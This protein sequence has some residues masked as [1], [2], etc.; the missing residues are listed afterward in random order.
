VGNPITDQAALRE[1]LSAVA[2]PSAD[3]YSTL[4]EYR[5]D[6]DKTTG[7]IAS[8]EKSAG[9]SMAADEQAVLLLEEQIAEAQAQSDQQVAL[10]QSQLE[11]LLGIETAIQT[12]A[13]AMAAFKNAKAG[14]FAGV[15]PVTGPTTAAFGSSTNLDQFADASN[16]R[17]IQKIYSDVL[18][19]GADQAGLQYYV[20]LARESMSIAAIS[21]LISG[22]NEAMTGAIPQFASGG[23]HSGGWRMVGERGPELEYTGPS[24]V[25]SNTASKAAL[26]NTAVVAE[27][28]SL[29]SEQTAI[30]SSVARNSARTA[31][32][33]DKWDNIGQPGVDP[34]SVGETT[35]VLGL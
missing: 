1:A 3:T 4:E 29:R 32:I 5:K 8:L 21:D 16:A 27:L 23:M 18:G 17:A 22:S 10:L 31:Q 15:A 7:V 35:T 19:R 13:E 6:F 2:S 33:L 24:K 14:G 30:G 26:D 28:R 34:D 11:G 9:I 25:M 12:L 20:D